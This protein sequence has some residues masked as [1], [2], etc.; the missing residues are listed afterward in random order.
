M[1]GRGEVL[2][3]IMNNERDFAAARD[4]H[5]YRIPVSSAKKWLSKCWP[6]QWLALYQTKVFGHEAHAISYY[7]RVHTVRR[8]A[9]WQLSRSRHD[10]RQA[11]HQSW[12]W[13]AWLT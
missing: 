2:V 10:A 13:A 8:V 12:L 11:V 4:Q 7:A 1:A 5:W 6:P 3:A 9:R